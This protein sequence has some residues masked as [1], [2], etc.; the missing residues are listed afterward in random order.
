V[1]HGDSA[2]PLSVPKPIALLVLPT[3]LHLIVFSERPDTTRSLR[4]FGTRVAT[5]QRALRSSS[6][7]RGCVGQ[8]WTNPNGKHTDYKS[9]LTLGSEISRLDP[10]EFELVCFSTSTNSCHR[11]KISDDF[12][13]TLIEKA[14]I[15]LQKGRMP[16]FSVQDTLG[17]THQLSQRNFDCSGAFA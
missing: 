15:F 1:E 9:S 14:Q 3:L 16:F 7:T 17:D 10:P 5:S 6:T 11:E 2:E 13:K 12:A 8:Q 4:Q